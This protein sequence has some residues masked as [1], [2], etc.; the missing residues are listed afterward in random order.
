MTF[1]LLQC[2]VSTV[3]E[4]HSYCTSLLYVSH[5]L[6]LIHNTGS[7]RRSVWPHKLNKVNEGA[8][9]CNRFVFKSIKDYQTR[10]EWQAT[11]KNCLGRRS[12]RC[13]QLLDPRLEGSR[14]LQMFQHKQQ[15]GIGWDLELK[16]ITHWACSGLPLRPLEV[17]LHFTAYHQQWTTE[18]SQWE[19]PQLGAGVLEQNGLYYDSSVA[20]AKTVGSFFG[21]QSPM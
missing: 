11:N 6:I 10:Q 5:F 1:P 8:A 20:R 19:G 17:R 21:I 4:M 18:A 7:Q 16:S 13:Q 2:H 15:Q 9:C 12:Q 14:L 3:I